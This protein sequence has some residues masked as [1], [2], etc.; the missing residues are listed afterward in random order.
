MK[1]LIFDFDGVLGDTTDLF[2]HYHKSKNTHLEYEQA[3][4]ELV[5][6]F[7]SPAHST[8]TKPSLEKLTRQA[9]WLSDF[10]D[11]ATQKN[12]LPVNVFNDFIDEIVKLNIPN[13]AI[14]SSGTIAYIIPAINSTLLKP[15][16]ILGFED[17]HSKEE[18][19][20]I[21]CNDWEVDTKDIIYFTDTIAD[22]L[23]VQNMVKTVIG[24]TW[25]VHNY[26][27]LATVLPENQILKS[28]YDIHK[29]V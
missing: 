23:E 7:L 6:Y 16:H 11:F 9:K 18:K 5:D 3:Y 10:V 13:K 14:V 20:K 2:V 21:I 12:W 17:H 8:S 25:G 1:N 27:L 22:V 26:D 24:C 4:K 19:I 28:F 15:S 29:L